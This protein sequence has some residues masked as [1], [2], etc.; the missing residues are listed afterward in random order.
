MED[1][2]I[3]TGYYVFDVGG[4]FVECCNL[5]DHHQSGGAGKRE[6][7]IPYA[8][9]GLVWKKI[10]AQ[11][12]GSDRAAGIIDRRLGSP[13]DAADNGLD[14]SESKWKDVA[15][16][17][18]QNIFFAMLP[19]W[20]EEGRDI[21]AIFLECVE[22]AKKILGREIIQATDL[23]EAEEAVRTAYRNA[24]DKRII[25]LDKNYPFEYLLNGYPEPLYAVYP[26]KTPGTWGVKAIRSDLK[27]FKNRKD[28]PKSWGGLRG[29]ELQKLT[30]IEDALFCH[31]S[32]FF[33][34]AGSKEG[35]VQL[36]QIAVES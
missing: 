13:I 32:L 17:Y 28:L 26:R 3:K 2:K 1:D 33:A 15:P 29:E 14:I 12:S 18:I 11:V 24:E 34:Q 35:A 19:T 10:G 21:D 20:K 23:I 6:N 31:H 36:A 4:V 7:G 16:Y 9:F 30:G 27:A 25:I 5:F 8:A 22:M